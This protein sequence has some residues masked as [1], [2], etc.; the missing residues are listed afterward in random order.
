MFEYFHIN[1]V[2]Q[3]TFYRIPKLLFTDVLY[4]GLSTDAKVLY[5]LML[6]RMQLSV[7][8]KWT[9][10]EGHIYIYFRQGE[11]M[12]MLGCATQKAAKLVDELD[13]KTGIGL[14]EILNQGLNKP[15]IIYVRN[16]TK[17]VSDTLQERRFENQ[18]SG[19]LKIKCP[20]IRKSNAMGFE[21]QTPY[22]ML[23]NTEIND[24]DLS[25]NRK[26][27]D[28]YP[29]DGMDGIENYIQLVKKN[30]EYDDLMNEHDG[31]GKGQTQNILKLII[32]TL[33]SS[34]T[35]FQINGVPVAAEYVKKRFME[36]TK[37]DVSGVILGL[38][39]LIEPI[40][41]PRNYLLTALY[42]APATS[43]TKWAADINS[44]IRKF[45]EKK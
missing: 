31:T 29:A 45:R 25:I 6:D 4:K 38:A 19:N 23:N 28:L 21:N 27:I 13:I 10:N 41:N 11:I 44:T 17:V 39:N 34:E 8:N 33:C 40:R 24:T 16:F 20:E 32:D 43:A 37:E 36:L 30:I 15:R 26:F 12:E 18:M 9:D 42:N 1:E 7:K 35:T 5:G 14:I 22:I 3:Y 2:D